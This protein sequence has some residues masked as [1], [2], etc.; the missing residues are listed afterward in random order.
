MKSRRRLRQPKNPRRP[1][2]LNRSRSESDL[3]L[4][5]DVNRRGL[6]QHRHPDNFTRRELARA[7][8]FT[9]QAPLRRQHHHHA[10]GLEHA[11]E[12]AHPDWIELAILAVRAVAQS[13]WQVGDNL[14]Y[15]RVAE[16]KR[17]RVPV[18]EL[19]RLVARANVHAPRGE[20][21]GIA[22]AP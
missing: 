3:A 8:E 11:R 7:L 22:S 18:L 2:A 21:G 6:A 1:Q 16:R 17:A 5:A 14:V 12:L 4:A 20:R 10:A 15:A 19:D 9:H 13:P